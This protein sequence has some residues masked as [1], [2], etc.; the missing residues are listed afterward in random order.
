MYHLGATTGW[1]PYGSAENNMHLMKA[2]Q[3]KIWLA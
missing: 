2:G 1:F 3:G